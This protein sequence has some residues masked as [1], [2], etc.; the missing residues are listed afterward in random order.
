MAPPSE[1]TLDH[2]GKQLSMIRD[3]LGEIMKNTQNHKRGIRVS[4]AETKAESK[5]LR[6]GQR[7]YQL[8][9]GGS[10]S[11]RKPKVILRCLCTF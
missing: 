7:C 4:C 6:G 9:L 10:A 8:S 2:L 3:W 5:R 11:C 1:T